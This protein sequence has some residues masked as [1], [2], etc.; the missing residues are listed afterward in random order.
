MEVSWEFEAYISRLYDTCWKRKMQKRHIIHTILDFALWISTQ[1]IFVHFHFLDRRASP[2]PAGARSATWQRSKLWMFWVSCA[3]LQ[4]ALLSPSLCFRFPSCQQKC[5]SVKI[6]SPRCSTAVPNF[7]PCKL[8]EPKLKHAKISQFWMLPTLQTSQW[9]HCF[10]TPKDEE[11]RKK[12]AGMTSKEQQPR[13]LLQMDR[14]LVMEGGHPPF[15]GLNSSIRVRKLAETNVEGKE[16]VATPHLTNG[17]AF[18]NTGS[19]PCGANW[20]RKAKSH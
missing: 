11:R 20:Q 17:P 15:L 5:L 2:L 18:S 14:L 13:W 6:V 4:S 7:F 10:A 8:T 12:S 16:G 19:M 3:I 9:R 1:C